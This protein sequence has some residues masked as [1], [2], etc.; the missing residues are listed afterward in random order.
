MER[1][2]G[3]FLVGKL[4]IAM[5]GMEDPRFERSVIFVCSHGDDGAMGLIVNKPVEGVRFAELL[6]RYSLPGSELSGGE[7]PDVPVLFGG[8]VELDRGFILHSADYSNGEGTLAV[9]S[10]FS[11]T[12][13]V[14]ILKAIVRGQGPKERLLALGYSGWG[15]G[16]IEDEIRANGWIH[17]DADADLVFGTDYAATWQKAIAKLGVDLSGLTGSAGRA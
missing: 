12:A 10:E 17:C 15:E 1:G 11:L 2:G 7:P 4:L 13:S 3:G 8:P 5:P 14:D 16:Q 6:E 9:T